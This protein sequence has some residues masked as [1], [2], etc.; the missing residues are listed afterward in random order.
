MRVYVRYIL[1]HERVNDKPD[2]ATIEDRLRSY[3]VNG[4]EPM[5]LKQEALKTRDAWIQ[6]VYPDLAGKLLADPEEIN[7]R[8]D[9]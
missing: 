9:W 8:H 3:M 1:S 6:R 2:E 7:W 5:E 4:T